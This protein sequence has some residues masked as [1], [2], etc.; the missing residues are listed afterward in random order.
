MLLAIGG[1]LLHH[2]IID[3]K[4]IAIALVLG[5]I[6]GI[7]LGKVHMTAVPQ[8]TAV[9]HAFGALLRHAGGHG[10]ILPARAGRAQ[11]MMAVLSAWK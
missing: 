7:P 3:Y 9:S 6:I 8:R 11:F 10:G 4:W 5:A 2:G 1:T